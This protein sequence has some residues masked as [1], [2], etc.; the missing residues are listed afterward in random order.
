MKR[1]PLDLLSLLAGIA[2]LLFAGAYLVGVGLGSP[3]RAVFAVPLLFV[4]LGVA[5]LTTWIVSQQRLAVRN[6]A[7]NSLD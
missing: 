3:P 5:G 7:T 4:G 6:E 2:F 1:H